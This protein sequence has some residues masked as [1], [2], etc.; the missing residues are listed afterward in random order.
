MLSHMF[1]RLVFIMQKIFSNFIHGNAMWKKNALIDLSDHNNHRVVNYK[2]TINME[3]G[4]EKLSNWYLNSTN[5]CNCC[6]NAARSF[7]DKVNLSCHRGLM[8]LMVAG[9]YVLH[10]GQ[11]RCSVEHLHV[12][13]EE[14]KRR[15]CPLS[16]PS[17]HAF[18]I[19]VWQYLWENTNI[20]F[21]YKMGFH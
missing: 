16:F 12:L 7:L 3:D 20:F 1:E 15:W 8:W 19:V 13:I 4:W 11:T 6:N 14:W 18:H 21:K 9:I 2:N 10:L 5:L 17:P